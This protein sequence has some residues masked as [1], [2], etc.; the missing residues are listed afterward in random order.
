VATL[1]QATEDPLLRLAYRA[2]STLIGLDEEGDVYTIDLTKPVDQAVS[3]SFIINS[4]LRGFDAT[5]VFNV[6][7]GRIEDFRGT[8]LPGLCTYGDIAV[9]GSTILVSGRDTDGESF[10]LRITPASGGGYTGKVLVTS[11]A[12]SGGS[13]VSGLGAVDT[14]ARGVAVNAQGL[15]VT[16]LP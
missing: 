16:T 12:R 3:L 8:M 9:N 5:S 1:A 14:D 7:D 4:G 6:E 15:A 2:N 13:G 10:V 11:T